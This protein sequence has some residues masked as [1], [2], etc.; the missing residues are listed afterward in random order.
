M[1]TK[2][3]QRQSYDITVEDS[4]VWVQIRNNQLP[5]LEENEMYQA[6]LMLQPRV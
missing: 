6:S 1:L 3:S 5:S 4:E 2:T